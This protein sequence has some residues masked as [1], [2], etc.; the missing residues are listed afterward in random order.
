MYLRSLL[1][2]LFSIVFLTS[3]AQTGYDIQFKV[4]GLKDTTAYLGYYYGESTFIRDTAKVNSKGEFRFDGKKNLEPGVYFLVLNSTKLVEFVIS[5]NQRFALETST[6][7]YIKNMHVKN[8]NDNK[9]FFDNMLFNMDRNKEAD[10]YVKIVKDSTL[11]DDKKKDAR[12]A[13]TKI[14]EKVMAHQA[15]IIEKYPATMTARLF[16]ASKPVQ[17]PDPPKKADGTTDSTF[18]LRWYRQHFFDNFDLSDDALLRLPKPL[19][20]EKLNEYVDKLYP[21]QADTINRVIDNLVLKAKKNQETYKYLVY[22]FMIKYQT[23]KIMGMDEVFV[24]LYDKYFATGEMDYWANAKMK[25]NVKDYAERIRLS[26]LGKQAPDL[27]MKDTNEKLQSLYNVK[28][29]YTIVFFFDPD[30]GHCRKETPKLVEFYNKDKAKYNL[31]VFAVSTDSSMTKLKD[32]IKEFK[33]NWITVNF[34][35]SA[36]GHYQQLY[37]AITT[38]T[39]YVLDEKKKIIGKKIPVEQLDEFLSNYQKFN[40]KK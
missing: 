33:T 36:V 13:L 10:P 37:D 40:K 17:I 1:S 14:N 34:Y 26:M 11:S 39:L 3:F 8:D 15:E 28:T 5:T 4:Q 38:P 25:S 21:P 7:D 32:F 22:T 31:E 12:E 24:H 2:F 6:E 20:S 18:Q 35:Y 9:L 23:P 27:I 30:C 29:K 19:Y 16:K